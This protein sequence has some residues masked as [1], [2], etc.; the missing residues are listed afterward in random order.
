[1]AGLGR[2]DGRHPASQRSEYVD[3]WVLDV[4][5]QVYCA[6]CNRPASC[7]DIMKLINGPRSCQTCTLSGCRSFGE[8]SHSIADQ[9]DY[10]PS[11]RRPSNTDTEIVSST[12]PP[13]GAAKS[14]S[15][16]LSSRALDSTF[17]LGDSC[18]FS[19]FRQ[20]VSLTTYHLDERLSL[21][22]LYMTLL[23]YCFFL[24]VV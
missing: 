1:M 5:S 2:G 16:H 14:S 20:L 24:S 22:D 10:L 23:V 7:T 4:W 15:P 3:E 8:Q 9:L 12:A 13:H 11:R 6:D 18:Q 17:G 21:S 19:G